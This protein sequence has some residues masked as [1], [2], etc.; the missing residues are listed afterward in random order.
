M[1]SY[2]QIQTWVKSYYS[3]APKICCISDVMSDCGLTK[4]P[5]P[6]RLD[7][8]SRQY[9]CPDDK[10]PA[11]LAVSCILHDLSTGSP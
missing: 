5:A 8:L 6:N 4:W 9:P 3:F 11:I 10:C 7:S 1:A 2:R